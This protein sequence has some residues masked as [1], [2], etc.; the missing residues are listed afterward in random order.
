MTAPV[1]TN[2]KAANVVVGKPAA[3]GGVLVGPLGTTLPATATAVLDAALVATGYVSDGG[4]TQQINTSTTD[5]KAWG[6]N[7]VRT[8]QTDHS[9]D[10]KFVLIET[11]ERSLSAYYGEANVTDATA[12]ITAGDLPHQV[13]VIEV[14]DGEKRVRIVIPDGQVTARDDIVFQDGG[15]VTYGLTV[16]CYPDA[17]GVKA[18]LYTD[19]VAA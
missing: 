11:S 7:T 1:T 8:V 4:V 2:P 17:D 18:Y 6:G 5:I 12:R 16:S 19:G 15:A 14:R 9:L 3:S 13:W 10:Y